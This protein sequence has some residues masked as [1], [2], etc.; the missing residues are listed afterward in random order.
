MN[1]IFVVGFVQL[2]LASASEIFSEMFPAL[3]DKPF[4]VFLIKQISW[5]ALYQR[6]LEEQTDPGS[7]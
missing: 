3:L 2:C 6:E 7:V 5:G 1:N 4:R